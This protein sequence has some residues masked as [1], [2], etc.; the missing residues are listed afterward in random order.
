M[1]IQ[2]LV[3]VPNV[4]AQHQPEYVALVFEGQMLETTQSR[5]SRERD[6]L[7]NFDPAA[8]NGDG[9]HVAARIAQLEAETLAFLIDATVRHRKL[10]AMIDNMIDPG[11]WTRNELEAEAQKI[12]DLQAKFEAEN[13]KRSSRSVDHDQVKQLTEVG[14]T[15][16]QLEQMVA[17]LQ[18]ARGAALQQVRESADLWASLVRGRL[19]PLDE[20]LR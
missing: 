6:A 3:S 9:A 14:A 18:E 5:L 10:G 4:P 7:R 15:Y 13:E 8:H 12:T 2:P 20:V 1:K 19:Q 16:R 11:G 17:A